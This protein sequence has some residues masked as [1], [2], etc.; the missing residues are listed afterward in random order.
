MTADNNYHINIDLF[1]WQ[2]FWCF[3]VHSLVL[4]FALVRFFVFPWNYS[5]TVHFNFK[6][7][8]NFQLIICITVYHV[9]KDHSKITESKITECASGAMKTWPGQKWVKYKHRFLSPFFL[10]LSLLLLLAVVVG[11]DWLNHAE[12]LFS[13][14][15][16]LYVPITVSVSQ[17]LLFLHASTHTHTHTLTQQTDNFSF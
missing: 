3:V 12:M 4:G 16:W 6:Q 15:Y 11:G 10:P 14:L 8:Y 1:M 5:S 7:N 13:Y 9:I 17:M 2:L